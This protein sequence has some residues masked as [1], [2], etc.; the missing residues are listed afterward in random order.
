MKTGPA[1]VVS[2]LSF[3]IGLAVNGQ[4]SDKTVPVSI[5]KAIQLVDR[6]RTVLVICLLSSC[7]STTD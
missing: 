6:P 1:A 5:E 3:V 4:A 2:F 7:R